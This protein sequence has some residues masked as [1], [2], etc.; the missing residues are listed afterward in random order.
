MNFA[1]AAP[2]DPQYKIV[3]ECDPGSSV[4]GE[5]AQ[6][7]PLKIHFAITGAPACYSVTATIDGKEI[8]GYLLDGGPDAVREFEKSRADVEREAFRAIP[9]PSPPPPPPAAPKPADAAPGPTAPADTSKAVPKP[10]KKDE[11]PK[12]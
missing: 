10:R 2:A 8:K 9:V 5:I 12:I 3:S 4:R 7:T 6:D 11:G 1:P